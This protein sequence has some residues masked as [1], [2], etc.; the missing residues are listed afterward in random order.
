MKR[1]RTKVLMKKMSEIEADDNQDR[2]QEEFRIRRKTNQLLI[3]YCLFFLQ[4][5]I[6]LYC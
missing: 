3:S 4:Y 5:C 1:T 6:V 2:N